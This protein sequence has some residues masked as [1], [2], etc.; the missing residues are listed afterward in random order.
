MFVNLVV[1][2]KHMKLINL[3]NLLIL[4]DH[5]SLMCDILLIFELFLFVLMLYCDKINDFS[6]D[7]VYCSL[8]LLLSMIILIYTLQYNLTYF[9][10]MFII[11]Y[12]LH[13]VLLF[14]HH[15]LSI[16]NNLNIHLHLIVIYP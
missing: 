12:L 11:S 13:F 3:M 14:D 2:I 4:I 7:F 10:D 16:L 5:N 15:L 8:S 9:Y 1:L 6:H